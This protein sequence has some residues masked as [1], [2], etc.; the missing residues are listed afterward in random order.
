MATPNRSTYS[1]TALLGHRTATLTP[2]ILVALDLRSLT[3]SWLTSPNTPSGETKTWLNFQSKAIESKCSI[4]TIL[5]CWAAC[6]GCT[7]ATTVWSSSGWGLSGASEISSSWT[8]RRT[9][10]GS[11]PRGFSTMCRNWRS[12]FWTRTGWEGYTQ[13]SLKGSNIWRSLMS[14]ITPWRTFTE[15]CL[16][17]MSRWKSSS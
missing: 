17:T 15:T 9:T 10:S 4:R 5:R 11:Y 12:S 16:F 2:R 3:T 1:K 7:C 13:R 6:D 8:S 14:L